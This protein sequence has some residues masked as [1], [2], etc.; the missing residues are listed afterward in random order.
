[1][2]DPA[3]KFAV[4][5]FG[6]A[7]YFSFIK[8]MTVFMLLLSGLCIGILYVF[9]DGGITQSVDYDNFNSTANARIAGDTYNDALFG[10][11]SL[12]GGNLIFD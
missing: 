1:M 8:F 2:N 5:G 10:D 6:I 9:V 7:L 11:W 12:G 4:H 3:D